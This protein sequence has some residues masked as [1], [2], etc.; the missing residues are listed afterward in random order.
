M[1][2]SAPPREMLLQCHLKT[3]RLPTML[4]EYA[5][6]SR[7]A[8]AADENYEEYL[9]RLTDLEV[10]QRSA[11]ALTARIKAA[12]FPVLKDLDTYDFSAMPSVPKAKIVELARGEWIEQKFNLC[13]LGNAGTG[14][15]HLAIAL[16]QAACRAGKRVRFFTA[17]ALVNA[18][19]EAQKQYRLERFLGQLD[20]LDLLA[21]DE[22]GY[23]SFSRS[24]AELLFQIFAER[25]ERASILVTSN[26]AFSDWGS[27]FQGER[28]TAALLD[29][30]TH[31]C[32]IFEINGESYRFRESAKAAKERK[33]KG[34]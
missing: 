6:L 1:A 7:E 8:A 33:A 20:K 26:L 32:H 4:A 16:G 29:R 28:M 18:L 5:K 23:L 30:F 15:T 17:A 34:N 14:K 24:G 3:L 31:R 21:I 11:N 22:L 10:A 9:L 19:E 13:L 12:G 27:I 2:T 25:Y